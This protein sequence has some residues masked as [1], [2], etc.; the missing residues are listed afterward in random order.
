MLEC[1]TAAVSVQ[2]QDL[3]SAEEGDGGDE[4]A[5]DES[6]GWRGSLGLLLLMVFDYWGYFLMLF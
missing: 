5:E 3:G 6:L 2:G 4:E 1:K